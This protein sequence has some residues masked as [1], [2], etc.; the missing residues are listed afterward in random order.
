MG[1]KV[2]GLFGRRLSSTSIDIAEYQL[3]ESILCRYTFVRVL[4]QRGKNYEVLEDGIGLWNNSI[5][6]FAFSVCNTNYE[7][8]H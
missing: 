8:Q 3:F 5:L 2:R 4:T 1:T 6:F 7:L